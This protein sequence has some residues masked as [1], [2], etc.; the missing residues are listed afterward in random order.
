MSQ[1]RSMLPCFDSKP[2]AAR[3]D[4]LR[5]LYKSVARRRSLGR[6]A[7]RDSEGRTCAV[8]CLAADCDK[9]VTPPLIAE[10]KFID[11]IAAINDALPSESSPKQR[12]QHVM[13]WLRKEIEKLDS[14]S[15]ISGKP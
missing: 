9:G 3:S 7:L 15:K 8:G 12:W 2:A 5:L 6:G 13:G 14:A 1:L 4:L 11:E 10:S